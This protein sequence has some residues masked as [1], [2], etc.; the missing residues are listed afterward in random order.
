MKGKLEFVDGSYR[1]TEIYIRPVITVESS[2]RIRT[3]EKSLHTAH[4]KCLIAN[5]IR[6]EVFLDPVIVVQDED[7]VQAPA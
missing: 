3:E 2:C 4:E 6:G 1:F 7:R 5:S